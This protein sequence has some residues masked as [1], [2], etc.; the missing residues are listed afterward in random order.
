MQVLFFVFGSIFGSFLG[1]VIDRL[2]EKRDLVQGRSECDTCHTLLKPMDL[3]PIFSYL[4][5]RG[6]CRHC[7]TKLSPRYLYLEILTG[8]VFL[9]TYNHF[10]LSFDLVIALVFASLLI[11]IAFIDLDTMYIYD[12]F[13]IL[14]LM[15]GLIRLF[16]NPSNF[17]NQLLGAFIVSLPYLIL[18][19]ITKGIGGGDVKLSFSAGF[20]LGAPS[21][22]VGFVIAIIIGGLH[23][24][25]LLKIKGLELKTA[26]PF[27]P[28]LCIGFFFALLHGTSIASWYLQFLL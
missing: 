18:A 24:L 6:H 21:I 16:H 14:I 4:F 1:V 9:L 12:S 19:V 7:G 28:Y 8:T 15:L 13:Q 17:K 25:Y 2:P 10:N 5:N 22:L 23:G 26:I 11:V 27:G 3:V 20:L